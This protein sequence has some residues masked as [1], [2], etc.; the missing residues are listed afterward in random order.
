MA[1]THG[2]L[3][4]WI[5]LPTAS[6]SS[7]R[8]QLNCVCL[9][10]NPAVY[11]DPITHFQNKS[12]L[13]MH[14]CECLLIQLSVIHWAQ[15]PHSAWNMNRVLIRILIKEHNLFRSILVIFFYFYARLN[16]STHAAAKAA[17][18]VIVMTL[19]ECV[20]LA[21][22]SCSPV[23]KVLFYDWLGLHSDYITNT[24]KRNP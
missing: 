16:I 4:C 3:Q 12:S 5:I 15:Q 14:I 19:N 21:N 7:E 10:G 1:D 23:L 6:V 11:L 18:A 9:D 22:C 17:T 2:C 13:K 24:W 8:E 20:I